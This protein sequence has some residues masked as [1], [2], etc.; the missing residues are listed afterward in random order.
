MHF[1]M[2]MDA[3]YSMVL[4]IWLL[5]AIVNESWLSLN[6]QWTQSHGAALNLEGSFSDHFFQAYYPFAWFYLSGITRKQGESGDKDW[7]FYEI[8]C[9]CKWAG[10][11]LA[12]D[13]VQVG[14]R[15]QK[16]TFAFWI[17]WANHTPCSVLGAG[18]LV[19][20]ALALSYIRQLGINW[21]GLR[22]DPWSYPKSVFSPP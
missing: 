20:G 10:S 8:W 22:G 1:N 3:L 11:R 14:K 4:F 9:A 5:Q 19:P 16:K 6:T 2:L 13:T 21:P 15:K 12:E 18:L 17:V 7:R